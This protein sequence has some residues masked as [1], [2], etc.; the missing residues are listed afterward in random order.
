M[1]ES[2]AAGAASEAAPPAI[3]LTGL[4]K[5]LGA[6]T[7][8]RALD[9]EVTGGH[10]IVLRGSNGAGKTTLLRLLA[11]RLRPTRGRGA[12]FGFDLVERADEV[13]RRVGLVSVYGGNYPVLTARENLRMAARLGSRIP[14]AQPL[15]TR[16]GKLGADA[17]DAVLDRIQ[18][19]KAADQLV[20]TYSSGM[21]KRLG[22]GR[23][24]LLDPTLWLLDEP[25][26][27][28]DEDGKELV[29]DALARAKERGRTVLLASH[30]RERSAVLA[31]AELEL[32]DGWL[33]R[34]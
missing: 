1:S 6:A 27:A 12:V 11:T 5:R 18:L 8:L 28:L 23:L 32:E 14:T 29:D 15:A 20:R 9:L 19:S 7:V 10:L 4:S 17:I 31:D 3:Q 16:T 25:Y 21:K 13:R 30:E 33:R 24:L 2:R 26:A 34:A 22:L